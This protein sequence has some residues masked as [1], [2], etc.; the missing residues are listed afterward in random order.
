MCVV[1]LSLKEILYFTL[2]K[3]HLY[4]FVR[5]YITTYI[6]LSLTNKYFKPY[7]YLVNLLHFLFDYLRHSEIYNSKVIAITEII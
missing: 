7:F 6:K 2:N 1:S 5:C 4:I 3:R